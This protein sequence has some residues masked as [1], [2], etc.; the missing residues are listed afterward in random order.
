MKITRNGRQVQNYTVIIKTVQRL[1]FKLK[2]SRIKSFFGDA[3]DALVHRKGS[4]G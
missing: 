1:F 3:S 2:V 4:K